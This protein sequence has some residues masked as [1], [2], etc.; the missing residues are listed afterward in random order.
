MPGLRQ[1]FRKLPQQIQIMPLVTLRSNEYLGS[2]DTIRR[3]DGF[4]L[5][6]LTADPNELTNVMPHCHENSIISF[7]LAGDSVE[8]VGRDTN[9]RHAGDLKFYRAGEFHQVVIKRFPSRN[10]NFEIKHDLLDKYNIR[11]C[12]VEF[13]IKNGPHALSTFMR[14][15]REM[16]TN[17]QLTDTS[18]EILL[19]GLIGDSSRSVLKKPRWMELVGQILNDRWNLTTTLQSLSTE[20]GVHPVTISKY[21]S[22]YYYCTL[23]E[24]LRKLRIEKSLPLIRN[25]QM[26]LTEISIHCG[27]ADQS[28][29][30]RNFKRITGFLPREFKKL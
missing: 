20:V 12:D 29:F 30:T 27:F 26:S 23:G 24:Y 19:L 28:H 15:Y 14:T 13:A 2:I 9:M 10:I 3:F 8:T 18:I 16:G 25:S 22:R 17:D 11:Q 5:S 1:H 4:T 7:I 21:F 6:G